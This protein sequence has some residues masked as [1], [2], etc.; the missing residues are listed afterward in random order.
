MGQTQVKPP[1]KPSDC[2]LDP[3]APHYDELR[4]IGIKLVAAYNRNDYAEQDHWAQES[5][6][7]HNQ[8]LQELGL[9]QR[10]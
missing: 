2:V 4:N 6:R 9:P 7:V 1:P 5:E 10:H 8:C 3:N